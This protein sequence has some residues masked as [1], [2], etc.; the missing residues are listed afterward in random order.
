VARRPRWPVV[1]VAVTAV[2]LVAV[3]ALVLTRHDPAPAEAQVGAQ[4]V[5]EAG[6]DPFA[7][8]IRVV[9]VSDFP[10]TIR[11]TTH[12]TD[13]R[14]GTKVVTGTDPDV[15]GGRP[16]EL[17][18]DTEAIGRAIEGDPGRAAA[19]AEALGLRSPD[20]I[21]DR[22]AALT[23]VVLTADTWVTSYRYADG[24]AVAEQ[25]VLER[26]TSVLV[27][28]GG[29]PTVKCGN[30]NPLRPPSVEGSAAPP[31]DAP[32]AGY[33]TGQVTSVSGGDE[34]EQ[35]RVVDV[36]TGRSYQQ[37]V[38]GTLRPDDLPLVPD[39][40]GS[41]RFGD[42]QQAVVDRLTDELGPPDLRRSKSYGAGCQVTSVWWGWTD[43]DTDSLTLEFDPTTGELVK[44][45]VTNSG[46]DRSPR[47]LL[48]TPEGV[49]AGDPSADVATA[50]PGGRR[51][52]VPGGKTE[53]T[54]GGYTFTEA[55]DARTGD[56][57]VEIVSAGAPAC[58]TD[59]ESGD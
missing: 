47:V 40:I 52:A 20:G 3:W 31:D 7:E 57:Y 36:D 11:P 38:G 41:A 50:Y 8:A 12:G 56:R 1:A 6:A 54:A 2:A 10:T 44:Y 22:L 43:V 9:E 15:F 42:D 24:R 49:S 37:P 23:P 25:V 4:A 26:G 14:T 5:G 46:P 55:R 53:I 28:A 29:L 19:W 34:V 21:E 17:L 32:W 39:G 33:D 13:E 51:R 59:G 58:A 45:T 16:Q 18:C 27:D 30:A 35:F 48:A